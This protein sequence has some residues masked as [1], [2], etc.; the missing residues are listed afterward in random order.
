MS[1]LIEDANAA[2]NA[3]ADAGVD[4]RTPMQ[5]K[6]YD[7]LLSLFTIVKEQDAEIGDLKLALQRLQG[8]HPMQPDGRF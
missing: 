7:A 3:V 2:L 1:Q 6:I 5:A 8:P 4:E